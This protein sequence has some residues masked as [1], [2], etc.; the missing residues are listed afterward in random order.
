VPP[1]LVFNDRTLALLASQKPRTSAELLTVKGIG[2][3]KAADLG[4]VFLAA[5]AAHADAARDG[6]PAAVPGPATRAP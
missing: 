6:P 1:Y 2:E 3:K 5:I 4:P